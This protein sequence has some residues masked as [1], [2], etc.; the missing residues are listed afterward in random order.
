MRPVK[1]L[2]AGL[3][4]ILAF[5]ASA[6]PAFAQAWP[7]KT[8]RIVVP[9][10][11]GGSVDALGRVYA[12]RLQ[13][14]LKQSVIIDNRGGAGGNLGANVVAKSPPDGYTILLN[15]NGQAIS[16]SIYKTLPYDADKDLV[17]VTQL[18]ETS[19]VIVINPKLPAS[20]LQEFVALAKA[21]PGVLNYGSTGVGNA[22]HLTMEMFK[23]RAGID[24]Q[25]VP[26]TGDAPLFNT[27]MAGDIQAAL[28]P[29]TT[30]KAHV[31]S[32]AMRAIAMT[33]AK[34]VPTWPDTPTI[35]EQ[36]YPDFAVTGW[37][38]LLAPAGTPREVV[39]RLAREAKIA[40]DTPEV[41]Q[42]LK[43]LTLEPVASTPDEFEALYRADR[44][45]FKKIIDD[46]KIPLQD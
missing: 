11:P 26:F 5:A 39:E 33:T 9:F 3:A 18:V 35:A 22:L 16:P 1:P 43:N 42:A 19:T 46:A 10:P 45:K 20:N 30:A 31:E 24:V 27:L 38:G 41:R 14:Q 34:R 2:I 21:K 23:I 40:T 12:A 25:M 15:I 44:I 13:D 32:G 4:A 6:D 17:R 7:S 36:G 8:I 28:V 29:T 37:V